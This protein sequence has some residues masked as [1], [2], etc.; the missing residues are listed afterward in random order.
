MGCTIFRNLNY[1]SEMPPNPTEV[2]NCMF[3]MSR[4]KTLMYT[5][6]PWYP[7]NIGTCLTI[8]FSRAH[9]MQA[10]KR[11]NFNQTLFGVCTAVQD[12]KI[13][14]QAAKVLPTTYSDTVHEILIIRICIRDLDIEY[15]FKIQSYCIV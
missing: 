11:T 8:A 9:K 14:M 4:L 2:E 7:Y 5:S 15:L 3:S 6:T 12:N 1:F 10:W 13:N